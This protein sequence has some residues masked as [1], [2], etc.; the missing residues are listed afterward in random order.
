MKRLSNFAF[1]LAAVCVVPFAA[2]AELSSKLELEERMEQR[3]SRVVHAYDSFANIRVSISVR[4]VSAPLPG[5]AIDLKNFSGSESGGLE[6]DNI[7]AVRVTVHSSKFPLPDWIKEN[8][9]AEMNLPGVRKSVEYKQMSETM[10]KDLEMNAGGKEKVSIIADDLFRKF[11]NFAEGLMVSLTFKLMMGFLVLAVMTLAATTGIALWLTKKRTKE[12]GQMFEAKLLP[13]LSSIGSVGGGRSTTTMKIDG[14]A[15][16]GAGA[17]SQGGTSEIEGLSTKTLEALLTDA[18]WCNQDTY[19]AWLWSAMTSAQR[20]ALFESTAV[21]AEYLKYVQAQKK[22]RKDDHFDP[23]YLDPMK[24]HHLSQE[25]LARH[26]KVNPTTW[27]FLSPMRQE[28]LPLTLQE[29]LHCMEVTADRAKVATL[30][31]KPSRKRTLKGTTR[32]GELSLEDEEAILKMPSMVPDA[33][34]AGMS[35]LVWLALRSLEARQKALTDWS[36]EDLAEAWVGTPDVLA[37]L[38]EALPEKK[39]LMLESYVAGGRSKAN[40]QS[41]CYRALVQAGLKD[42][43]SEKRAA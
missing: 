24:L 13:A 32:F 25:D 3:I 41:D 1:I 35:S 7:D 38:A 26:V 6:L 17:T 42:F 16:S 23:R 20:L 4:G 29:R 34:R 19:A 18:Y 39:R 30:P 11:S 33:L 40:R 22:V 21:D 28:T 43:A 9:N 2:R 15:L 37:K 36:A 10:K 31:E 8:I 27:H 12:L 5:T 14:S